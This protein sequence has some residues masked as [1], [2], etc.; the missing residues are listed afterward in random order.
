M[1]KLSNTETKLKKVLLKKKRVECM[2]EIQLQTKN[3]IFQYRLHQITSQ[4]R[5]PSKVLQSQLILTNTYSSYKARKLRMFQPRFF[6]CHETK[7]DQFSSS[8]F[9]ISLNQETVVQIC[10][11]NLQ[12]ARHVLLK[13]W[14]KLLSKPSVTK[15]VLNKVTDL[16]IFANVPQITPSEIHQVFCLGFN[17]L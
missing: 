7:F 4:L 11:E 8:K 13:Q 3:L 6:F 9:S 2:K 5:D 14:Q 12:N 10:S 17:W 1:K 15:F 16:L